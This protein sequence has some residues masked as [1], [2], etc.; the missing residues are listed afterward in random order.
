M[1]DFSPIEDILDPYEKLYWI[2]KPNKTSFIIKNSAFG[3][4]LIA[5][6]IIAFNVNKEEIWRWIST[7]F[8]VLSGTFQIGKSLLSARNTVYA[9]TEKR[10]IIWTKH[11]GLQLKIIELDKII[12]SEMKC[13]FLESKFKVGTI[14]F[15][16]GELKVTDSKP[17]KVYDEWECINEPHKVFREFK[18][19]MDRYK[20]VRL[21]TR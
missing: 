2:G 6:G 7:A 8:L 5:I 13:D 4:L 16:T 10:A 19:A 21:G 3:V 20:S 11:V 17:E 14:K 18:N 15:F 9:F 12:D 1:N